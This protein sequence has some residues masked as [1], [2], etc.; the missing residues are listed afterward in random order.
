MWNY[1]RVC[2]FFIRHP[3]SSSCLQVAG[4]LIQQFE[5]AFWSWPLGSQV[6]QCWNDREIELIP[7]YV[8]LI[9]IIHYSEW[10]I[11]FHHYFPY[12]QI[13]QATC[14]W[15]LCELVDARKMYGCN[16]SFIQN[17]HISAN[18]C[19]PQRERYLFQ[20][21]RRRHLIATTCSLKNKSFYLGMCWDLNQL[22]DLLHLTPDE[23]DDDEDDDDDDLRVRCK[24]GCH[25]MDP[26]ISSR[27]HTYIY[28]Y[29]YVCV[30]SFW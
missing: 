28:I 17:Q 30:C 26:C 27:L 13:I 22:W 24:E 4:G 5:L 7:I 9:C 8:T 20:A 21:Q 16:L 18:G 6:A 2:P 14:T 19:V 3:V 11:T 1:Q 12:I 23:D 29:I 15:T 25:Q 10:F